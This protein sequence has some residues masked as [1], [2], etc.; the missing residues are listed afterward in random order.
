MDQAVINVVNIQPGRYQ[1][2]IEGH[3]CEY[4]DAR[5]IVMAKFLPRGIDWVNEKYMCGS[6]FDAFADGARLGEESYE[7]IWL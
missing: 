1:V 7:V 2:E 4:C 5:A 3:Y 6:H